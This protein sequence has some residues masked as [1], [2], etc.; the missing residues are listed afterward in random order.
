MQARA[1]RK[2]HFSL[3]VKDRVVCQG[4]SYAGQILEL[5]CVLTHPG[6]LSYCSLPFAS[7]PAAALSLAAWP[8]T[9]AGVLPHSRLCMLTVSL[10][11]FS[12]KARLS[13]CCHAQ[14]RSKGNHAEDVLSVTL[15]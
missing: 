4:T 2:P 6:V 15:Q 3:G 7:S 12:P 9:N 10:V 14:C 11:F 8:V 1:L 5:I 13:C